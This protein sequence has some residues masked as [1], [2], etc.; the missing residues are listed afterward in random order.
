MAGYEW[1]SKEHLQALL[2]LYKSVAP[3]VE[4]DQDEYYDEESGDHNND[5]RSYLE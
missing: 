2:K 3:E 5:D 4:E 1:H